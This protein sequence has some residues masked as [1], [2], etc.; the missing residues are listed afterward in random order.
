MSGFMSNC[1]FGDH[2]EAFLWHGSGNDEIDVAVVELMQLSELDEKTAL[3]IADEI[4]ACLSRR[5]T[6]LAPDKGQAAVVKDNQ[7]FAPCG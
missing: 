5:R 1:P 3:E 2:G 7:V 4:G 6:M